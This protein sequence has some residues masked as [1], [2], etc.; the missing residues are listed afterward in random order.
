M[1]RVVEDERREQEAINN[2]KKRAIEAARRAFDEAVKASE[3][4]ADQELKK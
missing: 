2:K 1:Q 3:D 4:E